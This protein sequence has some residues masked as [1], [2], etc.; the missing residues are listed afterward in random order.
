[1]IRI[2]VEADDLE[3]RIESAKNGWIARGIERNGKLLAD[4][5]YHEIRALD[6]EPLP[7][8]RDVKSVWRELQEQKCAYCEKPMA[9]EYGS[10]EHHVEHYRP[11]RET[12][13]WVETKTLPG[14]D[15]DFPVGMGRRGGYFW[16]TYDPANYCTAC[17]SCNSPL[18]S[19][20][21]PILGQPGDLGDD[22][23]TLLV[24]EKPILPFPI[25]ELDQDPEEIVRWNGFTAYHADTATEVGQRGKGTIEFFQLNKRQDLKRGRASQIVGL[26]RQ[27]KRE[28]RADLSPEQRQQARSR[29]DDALT[30]IKRPFA[31]C[32]RAFVRLARADWD[33]AARL[34]EAIEA[35]HYS[36]GDGAPS[37]RRDGVGKP[38]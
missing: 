19:S 4:G 21:F 36:L 27:L 3:Q 26:W 7:R 30:S 31:G 18:K 12:K 35:Y 5:N 24:K 8:W 25:G 9:E 10:G 22:P 13:P 20:R 34:F 23:A 16:L 29:V 15:L 2:P 38:G 6:E 17:G 33:S 28:R 1:M 14:P 32:V 37:A 11:K